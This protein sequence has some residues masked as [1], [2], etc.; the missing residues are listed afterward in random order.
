MKKKQT[1][2]SL[3]FAMDLLFL[4]WHQKL[5]LCIYFSEDGAMFDSQGV[6]I[7]HLRERD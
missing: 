7:M 2:V 3:S 5:V 6:S 1:I 4:N